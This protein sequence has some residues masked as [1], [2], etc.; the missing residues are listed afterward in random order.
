MR[1]I[2]HEAMQHAAARFF[3]HETQMFGTQGF[4]A[5]CRERAR[6]RDASRAGRT[7][8]RHMARVILPSKTA[9]HH[10]RG[11]AFSMAQRFFALRGM[12]SLT[13]ATRTMPVGSGD[14]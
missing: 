6:P 14:R 7:A 1:A 11:R 13:P 4:V 10:A 12:T 3:M 2:E 5:L 8:S 9:A